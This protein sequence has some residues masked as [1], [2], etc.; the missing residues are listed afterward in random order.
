MFSSGREDVHRAIVA[1][2]LEIMSR[3]LQRDMYGLK[4]PGYPVDDIKQ[5]DSDLL[6]MSRYSC[7]YW[8]DHLCD[9]NAV[10]LASHAEDLQDGGVVD[11]FIREKYLYWLE[12]LSLCKS[13]LK[14]VVLIAKLRSLVQVCP[15]Q[16]I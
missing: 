5:L 2:S 4:V 12:A 16:A 11:V 7:I 10:S 9:S 15:Q 8:V 13:V 1:R 6:A 3:T 14:G